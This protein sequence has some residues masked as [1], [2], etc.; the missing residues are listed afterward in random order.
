MSSKRGEIEA[1]SIEEIEE[2]EKTREFGEKVEPT[3]KTST[4]HVEYSRGNSKKPYWDTTEVVGANR[5]LH[6]PSFN[7]VDEVVVRKGFFKRRWLHVKRYWMLYGG[8]GF[9]GLA[10]GLPLLSEFPS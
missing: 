4:Q 5:H 7:S 2:A 1:V 6:N 3:E 8:A 10:A 9:I